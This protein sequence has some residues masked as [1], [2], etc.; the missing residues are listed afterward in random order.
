MVG[1]FS[2]RALQMYLAAA[3]YSMIRKLEGVMANFGHFWGRD[4]FTGDR[5]LL[6]KM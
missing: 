6:N 5:G 2:P 4:F 1:V 3:I